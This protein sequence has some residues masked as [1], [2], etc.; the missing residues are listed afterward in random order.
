MQRHDEPHQVEVNDLGRG[1]DR[2]TPTEK[3]SCDDWCCGRIE[4]WREI[5]VIIGTP[6]RGIVAPMI[7][8]RS[9]SL[10]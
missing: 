6:C 7:H 4:T 3:V 5:Y 2:W 1:L 10:K 9:N 8:H